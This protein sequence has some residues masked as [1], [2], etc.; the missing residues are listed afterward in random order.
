MDEGSVF[1]ASRGLPRALAARSRARRQALRDAVAASSSL[2]RR[3]DPAPALELTMRPVATLRS[4]QRRVR[5]L[6]P[7]HV[8][9]IRGSIEVLGFSVPVLIAGDGEIVDGEARVEAVRQLGIETIACVVVD[10]LSAEERRLLRL[11][12]NRLQERGSWDLGEL[13]LE[14]ESLIELEMPVEIAGFEPP[15]IDLVLG[16]EELIIDQAANASP[17]IDGRVPAVS[18]LGDLW[19]LGDHRLVCGDARD[20]RAYE[21]MLA[22][23]RARLIF[24]D[25]P[26]NCAIDG[27]VGG[28]GEIRHREFVAAAGE[29]SDAEFETFLGDFL[30]NGARHLIDGGLIYAFM[31]WRQ[32]ETLLRAGRRA[33]LKQ[34]NLCVWSKPQGGMG[35]LYRSA[36][37]LIAVFKSGSA[38]H[39]N[40]VKLGKH[41]RDRTNVWTYPGASS[42]GSDARRQLG[43][44]PTPKPVELV[45][46]ALLDASQ[47]GDIVLDPFLGSGTTVI[48]AEKTGRLAAGLELDPLYVDA[49][50]RR[51][52]T[53]TGRT[54]VHADTG[55]SMA[56]VQLWREQAPAPEPLAA[57]DDRVAGTGAPDRSGVGKAGTIDALATIET[58]A[59]HG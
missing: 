26:Y 48:A 9:R 41:G 20:P 15:E 51:W 54:A 17:P 49:I 12:V 44:H 13:K 47:R 40:N 32:I 28:K 46:D 52:Q 58:E 11:A 2:T 59:R 21:M 45:A 18:R 36:H 55:K 50:V 27:F 38:A 4:G 33:A 29:L 25:P 5:K 16:H 34:I 3:N 10:H 19:L 7:E 30:R 42:L 56:E 1:E 22:G 37:E 31:D 57:T 8:N 39:L 43:A 6:D 53:F 24:T 23:Q 35:G 14:F